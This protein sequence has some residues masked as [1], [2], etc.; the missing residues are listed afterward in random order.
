MGM[1][2][3]QRVRDVGVTVE[4]L[5]ERDVHLARVLAR[6]ELFDGLVGGDGSGQKTRL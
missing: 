1:E 3:Y 5:A 2:P 4:E 6:A